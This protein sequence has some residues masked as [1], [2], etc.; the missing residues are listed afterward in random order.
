MSRKKT[1][2]SD[3]ALIAVKIYFTLE[4]L[5]AGAVLSAVLV[6][7]PYLAGASYDSCKKAMFVAAP[8]GAIIGGAIAWFW[9]NREIW[10]Y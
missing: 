8:I 7:L 6:W 9:A 5:V 2:N 1:P 3:P 4:G 10:R